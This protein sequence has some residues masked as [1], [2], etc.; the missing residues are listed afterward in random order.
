MGFFLAVSCSGGAS[1]S[2]PSSIPIAIE[3]I[4]GATDVAVDSSFIYEF[5]KAVETSTVTESSFFIVQTPTSGSASVVKADLD[6]SVC[7]AGAR[8]PASIEVDSESAIL[9]PT[10]DLSAG[11][12][13]TICLTG[14]IIFADGSAFTPV[15]FS[16]TTAGANSNLSV[17]S[18]SKSSNI[19]M[20]D[21]EGSVNLIFTFDGDASALSPSVRVNEG[22]EDYSDV[23][24][25]FQSGSTT[26]YQCDVGAVAGCSRFVDYSAYLTG[27]G[28]NSYRISFN[29]AD[30]EGDT[31]DSY[32]ETAA[33]ACWDMEMVSDNTHSVTPQIPDDE[34]GLWVSITGG[35]VG[36]D[37]VSFSLVRDIGELTDFAYSAYYQ[38]V[39][40]VAYSSLSGDLSQIGH[41]I[42][43]SGDFD[44]ICPTLETRN[45]A[46]EQID[47]WS[48]EATVGGTDEPMVP[49]NSGS[50]SS[51]SSG[52]YSPMYICM[53][54]KDNIVTTYISSDG[55]TYTQATVDNME[56]AVGNAGC[57]VSDVINYDSSSFSEIFTLVMENS[58]EGEVMTATL[59]YLRFN[60][61]DIEG[62]ASDCPDF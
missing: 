8:L 20:A 35:F 16:F 48:I 56:C 1:P 52:Y 27:T 34:S 26:I 39:N 50:F 23:S 53:V 5:D 30:Y 60:V 25:A 61:T 51:I 62:S 29:S 41:C 2:T 49:K 45:E 59:G 19:Y 11:T 13:Y 6:A 31:S 46:G 12:G 18:F 14:E 55:E 36:S 32:S 54:S 38:T 9:D 57:N 58:A 42:S 24:C 7:I 44:G 40:P 21:G 3:G 17:T 33:A 15:Q 10:N 37:A 47:G 28:I 4:E 22:S 43:D